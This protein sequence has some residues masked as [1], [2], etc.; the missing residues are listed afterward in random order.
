M[1]GVYVAG[2][3]RVDR[4]SRICSPFESV[5]LPLHKMSYISIVSADNEDIYLLLRK[6]KP[7]YRGGETVIPSRRSGEV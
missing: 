1:Q 5:I 7:R 4:R 2:W 6:S 3:A